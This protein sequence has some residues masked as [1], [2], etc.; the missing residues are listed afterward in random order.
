VLD[1]RAATDA[2]LDQA[3]RLTPTG[4]DGGNT[5]R[6]VPAAQALRPQRD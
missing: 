3:E 1:A 2:L 6:S 4:P 5:S